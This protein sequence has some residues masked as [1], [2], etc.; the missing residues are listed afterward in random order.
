MDFFQT[1]TTFRQEPLFT[2]AEYFAAV[3]VFA[4]YALEA[5]FH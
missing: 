3:V 2:F 1:P 5:D 4:C